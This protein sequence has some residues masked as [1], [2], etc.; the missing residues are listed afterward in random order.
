MEVAMRRPRM[1]S[2]RNTP[3]RR[4]RLLEGLAGASACELL[5][6]RLMPSAD[7]LTWHNDN[8]R[9][10]VNA[11]ETTLTPANVNAQTFGKVGLVT[12][13]GQLY[14]QPLVKSG[15]R[16]P[17]QGVHDVVYVATE[18]DSVY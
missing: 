18:H 17:G 3:R 8:A 5:E 15:V 9:T 1:L 11:S 7:V 10:G 2:S 14:A 4:R 12:V 16:I 6:P 13:D